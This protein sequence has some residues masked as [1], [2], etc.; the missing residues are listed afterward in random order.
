MKKFDNA[1]RLGHIYDAICWIETHPVQ[2]NLPA[3]KPLV[4]KLLG[5]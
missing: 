1:A 5:E 2:N 3:L 4:E